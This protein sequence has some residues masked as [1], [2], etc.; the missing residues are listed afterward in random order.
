M[1]DPSLSQTAAPEPAPYNPLAPA[2][3]PK[4]PATLGKAAFFLG[5][6]VFVVSLV[7]SA[8]NGVGA[9][10]F[11]ITSNGLSYNTNLGSNDPQE[12]AVSL[13]VLAHVLIGT[14]AGITALVLGI[15]AIATNR[16]RAFGVI[17]AILAFLAPGLSLVLFF[18]VLASSA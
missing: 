14:L 8:L 6:A 17:G 7:V 1:T 13:A 3:Q 4:K 9:A 16:G 2:L 11:A 15:I 5:L 10:P 18:V 12:V